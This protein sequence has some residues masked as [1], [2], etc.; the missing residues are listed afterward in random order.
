MDKVVASGKWDGLE[1]PLEK[2]EANG[3]VQEVSTD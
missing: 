1:N 2:E 3:T